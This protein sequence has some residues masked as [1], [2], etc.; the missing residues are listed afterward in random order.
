M[1]LSA[2]STADL[3]VI[4][5]TV[6]LTSVGGRR[7]Q[8]ETRVLLTTARILMCQLRDHIVLIHIAV[9]WTSGN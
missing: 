4:A 2:A 1:T 9:T 5:F 6:P 8:N 7:R 3:L